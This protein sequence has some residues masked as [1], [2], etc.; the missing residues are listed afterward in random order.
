MKWLI[1]LLLPL[2]LAGCQ[3]APVYSGGSSGEAQTLLS[4]VEIMP[5]ADKSG[6]MVRDRLVERMNPSGNATLRLEVALDD[7]IIG[8][9]VRGDNSIIRERRTLRARYRLIEIATGA[10][11]LDTTASADAGIDVV[12]SEYAVVAAEAT[13]LERLSRDIADQIVARLALL[14]RTQKTAQAPQ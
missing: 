11:L 10:V 9:G 5:I 1:P 6:F 4:G 12:S 3:L 8:F 7:D 2:A 14:A 13:A